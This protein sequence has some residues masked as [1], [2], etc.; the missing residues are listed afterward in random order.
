VAL[1]LIFGTGVRDEHSALLR[2]LA[3]MRWVEI[4]LS[5]RQLL[6]ALLDCAHR[7]SR[8]FVRT[9]TV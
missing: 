6:V 2:A 7:E 4:V 1:D 9:C 8:H 5:N 3:I